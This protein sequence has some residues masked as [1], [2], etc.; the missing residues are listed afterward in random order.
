M[1]ILGYPRGVIWA[2]YRTDKP[3][4]L[5]ELAGKLLFPGNLCHQMCFKG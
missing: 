1:V 2:H 5:R 3:K 4:L